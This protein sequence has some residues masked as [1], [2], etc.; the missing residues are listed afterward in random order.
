[1]IKSQVSC[2]FNHITKEILNWTLHFLCIFFD[3]DTQ[4]KLKED[5][6]IQNFAALLVDEESG[7]GIKV[8]TDNIKGCS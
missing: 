1:M 2:G 5:H 7:V 6:E 8:W 3:L 4:E